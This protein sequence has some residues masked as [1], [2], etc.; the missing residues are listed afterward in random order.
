MFDPP[1]QRYP[2]KWK[3]MS[4]DFKLM[5]VYHGSMMVLFIAGQDLSVRQEITLTGI[6]AVVLVAI[7]LRH[8]RVMNWR[9]PSV[10]P[11]NV[12]WASFG[13]VAIAFFLFSATPLFPPS[14]HHALPWYFAGLGIGVFG[15][16][17]SL[18]V[19]NTSEAD[20][21][22]NC[23]IIDQYGRE[24]ERASDLPQPTDS[25][26]DWMRM[27]RGIY[28]VMFMLVWTFG[29]TS[30]FFFGN[31]FR[32]G[33]P[34]P[35]ATQ[36]EPLTDHDK[37]VFVTR[38]EKRRIDYFQLASEIGVPLVVVGGVILHFLVGVKLF[39][40]APTLSEYL[41]ERTRPKPNPPPPKLL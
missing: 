25:E 13:A 19:V 16:L 8:R 26:P 2:K 9:W 11:R 36:A 6:L 34:M 37:T 29:V 15:I 5:F 38:T 31:A 27:V 30:F 41:A 20:F 3:E 17:T 28:T 35:T 12:L 1:I 18:R 24:I 39:P 4:L 10:R 33:S 23:W 7:S 21:L 22:L 14:D 32:H 40:N